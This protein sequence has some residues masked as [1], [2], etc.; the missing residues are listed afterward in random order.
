[1]KSRRVQQLKCYTIPNKNFP[2][3]NFSTFENQKIVSHCRI[4]SGV[5]VPF[6]LKTL[7]KKNWEPDRCCKNAIRSLLLVRKTMA[8][9]F[10][11]ANQRLAL[12]HKNIP[13]REATCRPELRNIPQ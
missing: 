2:G 11:S 1:M 8:I 5:C 7:L 4:A 12:D 6:N 10:G 13:E 9:D 3:A